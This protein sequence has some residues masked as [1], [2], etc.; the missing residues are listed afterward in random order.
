MPVRRRV[1]PLTAVLAGRPPLQR[2]KG[3]GPQRSI[4]RADDERVVRGSS[5]RGR[6]APAIRPALR[7]RRPRDFDAAA[8]TASPPEAQRTRLEDAGD[9]EPEPQLWARLEDAGAAE[10]EL[11]AAPCSVCAQTHR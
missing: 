8:P 1:A 3:S 7:E 10:P 4:V 11:Q 9:A 6:A 5:M 2:L